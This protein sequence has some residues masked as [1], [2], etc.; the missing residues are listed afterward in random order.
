MR[1]PNVAPPVSNCSN[2][3]YTE[4][5]PE[6]LQVIIEAQFFQEGNRQMTFHVTGLTL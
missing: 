1:S 2:A 6:M 4:N 5:E 3:A